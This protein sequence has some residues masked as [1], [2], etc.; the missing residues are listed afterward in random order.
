MV[1]SINFV[2]CVLPHK[3]CQERDVLAQLRS[4][5]YPEAH[6]PGQGWSLQR[7][8]Q[9]PQKPNGQSGGGMI[10]RSRVL[11]WEGRAAD[12][13]AVGIHCGVTAFQSAK[14]LFSSSRGNLMLSSNS[15]WVSLA[16]IFIIRHLSQS[17][18]I[19]LQH[20]MVL[21]EISPQSLPKIFKVVSINEETDSYYLSDLMQ[22]WYQFN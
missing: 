5:A 20:S 18:F 22:I 9:F 11:G 2:I 6:Q 13:Q 10:S 16:I 14:Q 1:K 3:K 15:T 4:D 21:T 7:M 8:E 19:Y 17:L 12:R